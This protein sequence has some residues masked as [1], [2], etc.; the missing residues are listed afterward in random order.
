MI[1]QETKILGLIGY[2]LKHSISFIL[3]NFAFKQLN[4]PAIYL[5]IP[6]PLENISKAL[7]GL[8]YLP[9]YGLNVTIPYKELVIAYLDE[10]SILAK[11]IKAVN[12]ITIRDGKWYGDNTDVPGFIKTLED[13][14]LPKDIPSLVLG[15]GGAGRAVVFS[16]AE[17]GVQ[18]IYIT[19]RTK[20]KGE[21]LIKDLKYYYPYIKSEY[22]PW[23]DKEYFSENPFI[24][25][26][27]T[28]VGLDAKTSPFKIDEFS[29]EKIYL[30]YDIIYNPFKTPLI[31]QAEK[32]KI[33]WKNGLDMLIYQGI[34]AW[35][36][37]F[38]FMP[39]FELL[40]KEGER[41]LC[42]F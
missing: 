17:Y 2:P 19:N 5:N 10:I 31:L 21:N 23:E 16:L 37:W 28:S 13:L 38:G 39:S 7:E 41:Y 26:N 6:I 33:P 4:I 27:T 24:L 20:E 42:A 12:T 35:K 18:K 36:N 15:A 1:S 34:Y 25:I 14:K 40:K 9:L 8:K 32:F 30:V 11:K 29:N 3:H 22:I